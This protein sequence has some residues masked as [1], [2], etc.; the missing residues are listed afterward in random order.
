MPV[1]FD[2]IIQTKDNAME[3][4]RLYDIHPSKKLNL[5]WIIN[6]IFKEYKKL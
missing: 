2:A 4:M 1:G 5:P 6:H 3:D